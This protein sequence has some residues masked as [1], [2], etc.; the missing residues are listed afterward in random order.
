MMAE[1]M[2]GPMK[3]LVLPMMEKRE[4]KRNSLPRGVTSEIIWM[5]EKQVS[6]D[7]FLLGSENVV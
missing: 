2:K 5:G 3:E 1:E 4:K 7:F 6:G